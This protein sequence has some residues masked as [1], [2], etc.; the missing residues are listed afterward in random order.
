[1]TSFQAKIEKKEE[2]YAYLLGVEAFQSGKS[3]QG[4]YER[5]SKA[6]QDWVDGYLDAMFLR[7]L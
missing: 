1:V 3:M 7:K 5:N 6:D 4:P 2:S